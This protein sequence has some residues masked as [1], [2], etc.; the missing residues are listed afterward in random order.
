MHGNGREQLAENC[1]SEELGIVR[2]GASPPASRTKRWRSMS[3]MKMGLRHPR[4]SGAESAITRRLPC[5]ILAGLASTP[6]SRH[7]FAVTQSCNL[8]VPPNRAALELRRAVGSARTKAQ[9]LCHAR[10]CWNGTSHQGKVVK[11]GTKLRSVRCPRP[12]GGGRRSRATSVTFR[13]R[14]WWSGAG[15]AS[16]HAACPDALEESVPFT[17]TRWPKRSPRRP[18]EPLHFVARP[19]GDARREKEHSLD[20][21]D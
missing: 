19:W 18:S 2:L 4:D 13:T 11:R 16:E 6:P 15:A 21:C 10:Q 5:L 1:F 14:I 20:S 12:R 9:S 17:L 7:T 3:S 8:M